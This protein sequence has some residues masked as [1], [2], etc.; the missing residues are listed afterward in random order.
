MSEPNLL[1]LHGA[2]GASSQFAP[3]IPLLED[4]FELHTLDFEGHGG[5]D[6]AFGSSETSQL[7][8]QAFSMERCVRNVLDY[9]ERQSI[10]QTHISGDSMGD[11]WP[12]CWPWAIRGS[13]VGS[14]RS[15]RSTSGR[16]K[17]LSARSA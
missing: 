11:M 5:R 15:G 7:P 9:L 17:R 4:D 1:L 13:W 8:G 6:L 10:K 16:P 14:S 2:P 12:A 3:L